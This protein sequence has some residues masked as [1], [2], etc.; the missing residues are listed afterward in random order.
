MVRDLLHDPNTVNYTV[1][2]S[3]L[4]NTVNYLGADASLDYAACLVPAEFYSSHSV[5]LVPGESTL[6]KC[7]STRYVLRRPPS[8]EEMINT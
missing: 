3:Q 7:N 2:Y 6:D 1:N 4:S 5:N 8:V